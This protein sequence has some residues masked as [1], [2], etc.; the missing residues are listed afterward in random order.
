MSIL[1]KGGYIVDPENKLEGVYDILI[2]DGEIKKIEKDIDSEKCELIDGKGKYIFPGLVDMH[3]HLREPGREDEETLLSGSLSGIKGGFTTLCCMPN[4][5][6]PIDNQGIV[7]YIYN[8][9]KKIGL[10]DIFPVGAITKNLEGKELTEIGEL[11][12]A[13]VVA[14]SDDGN[15]VMDSEVMRRAME[16][17]KMFDLLVISHCEDKNL[18]RGGLMNEGYLSSLLGLKGI[19][20]QAEIVMVARDIEL[21]KLTEAKLHIAHVSTKETVELI[22]QA[23][24]RGIKVTA[25]TCPHYFSLTEERIL[26]YNTNCKVNPPLRTPEDIEAIKEGLRDGTID[27]IATDHAPHADF[28]K[29]VEFEQASFGMIG[30]ETALGIALKELIKTK[31]ISLSQL[32]EK[33]SLNPAKILGLDKGSINIGKPADLIIVDLDKSWE[34]KREKIVSKSKNTPFLNWTLPGVIEYVF[35]KGKLVLNKN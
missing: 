3:C 11:K 35:A 4:T 7:E 19:P 23:K 20:R 15:C 25:E 14:I 5:K 17:S 13:G 18:S 30:L 33:M 21:A 2:D 1:I 29:D 28:E 24:K 32:V 12:K 27:V 26:G 8:E 34:V 31:I 6:P 16:Y 9:N 10:M 22:R